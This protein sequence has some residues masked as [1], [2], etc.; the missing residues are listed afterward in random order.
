[1]AQVSELKPVVAEPGRP[2]YHA[3]KDA[4]R[5][6]IDRGRFSPGDQLPSTKALSE[7]LNVS[8]VTVHRAL[9][10]LVASGVLRRGQGRGT[11][12]H[13]DYASRRESTQGVRIGLVFNEES[14]LAD[15]F[16]GHVLEGVR[17]AA[18]EVG[19]DLVILQFGE[20]WRK[21]CHGFL[22]VNP[23]S[24]QLDR[25]PQFGRSASTQH[26]YAQGARQQT[27]A[28]VVGATVAK[29]AVCIDCNNV[30]LA[31]QAVQH[32][33]ALG[34][35]RIAFLGGSGEI[36]NNQD[37]WT[38]YAAALAE[39]GLDVDSRLVLRGSS[40]KLEK[41]ERSDLLAMLG[42]KERPTAIFAAGYYFALDVYAAAAQVG[43]SI[44]HEL[45]VVGV[46]DP[47]SAEYLSPPLTTMRQPLEE[48]GRLGAGAV[49]S[50]VR[51]TLPRP[52][53]TL[54]R[55]MLVQ[56][57]STAKPCSDQQVRTTH[58]S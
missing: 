53:N 42:R 13:E 48:L 9:Q 20:D 46:D 40:W 47:P 21:E 35:K 7:Q 34:H 56:R 44:P 58:Q 8:L 5:A 16:H 45:S 29:D 23:V 10:E 39:A 19:A 11:F 41:Q 24:T 12:V 52:G 22:Y 36:S 28:V 15:F 33:I 18:S 54:L 57:G 31:R 17:Q 51:R 2:L 30:D 55:A 6:A 49:L 38:G 37:R 43:L 1:M 4:V 3:V 14:S 26:G 25:S 27:A 32:L 50:L